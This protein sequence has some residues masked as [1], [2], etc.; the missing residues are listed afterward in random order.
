LALSLALASPAVASA[1]QNFKDIAGQCLESA[2]ADIIEA[3]EEG[4]AVVHALKPCASDIKEAISGPAGTKCDIMSKIP[5]I[6]GQPVTADMI[7]SKIWDSCQSVP[8]PNSNRKL[9]SNHSEFLITV[10]HVTALRA[11]SDA[12][13][14]CDW[15][16][17]YLRDCLEKKTDVQTLMMRAKKAYSALCAADATVLPCVNSVD[18]STICQDDLV[19]YFIATKVLGKLQEACSKPMLTLAAS[20]KPL[21]PTSSGGVMLSVLMFL[22]ILGFVAYLRVPRKEEV[23]EW[24]YGTV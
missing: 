1:C 8:E 24:S 2:K 13:E 23:Q 11:L 18:S 7:M 10:S 22:A 5:P 4:C 16:L 9:V 14:T 19:E 21:A 17:Y 15:E 20:I 12:S 6:D 3:V